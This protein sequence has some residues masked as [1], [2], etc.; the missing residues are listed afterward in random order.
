MSKNN[1]TSKIKF[2]ANKVHVH[3]WPLNSPVWNKS[4][5]EDINLKLNENP[6]KK[7]ILIDNQK[8]R[9]I[10]YEFNKIQK[11]GLTV[12]LF[13]KETRMVFEGQL[14]NINAHV[15]ITT[16]SENYL[17]IFNKLMGWKN[18]CFPDFP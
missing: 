10:N 8:I 17:D 16:N 7:E 14:K 12:P 11:I 3:H 5:K 6:D 9:I 1:P 15:H 18:R 13:K 2:L 4:T